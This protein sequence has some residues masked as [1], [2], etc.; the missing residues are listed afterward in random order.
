MLI[1]AGN[2]S[3][4]QTVKPV[5]ISFVAAGRA[6]TALASVGN[7]HNMGAFIAGIGLNSHDQRSAIDQFPDIFL[8]RRPIDLF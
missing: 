3:V 2:Q 8:D 5:E 7:K 4:K 1:G 6:K